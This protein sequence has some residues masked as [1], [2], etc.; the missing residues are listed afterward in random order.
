M[1]DLEQ[2]SDDAVVNLYPI[3]P[4]LDDAQQVDLVAALEKLFTQ[5]ERESSAGPG[6]IACLENGRVLMFAYEENPQEALSGCR[7]DKIAKVLLH[8]EEKFDIQILNAP[9]M[10]VKV[11]E[12]W[13]ACHRA[14]LKELVAAAQL[15]V[16]S[17]AY[18][19]R[20]DRL[21]DWRDGAVKPIADMWMAP[22]VERMASA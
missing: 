9:P 5:F 19:T 15:D 8:I 3:E 10:L 22:I 12:E 7:K 6:H 17:L 2:L 14:G 4:A 13:Q 21:A 20:C 11:G 18:D 1:Q 16:Q